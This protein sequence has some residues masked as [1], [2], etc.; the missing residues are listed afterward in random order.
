VSRPAW[1]PGDEWD[2]TDNLAVHSDGTLYRYA[3][4]DDE[5]AERHRVRIGSIDRDPV[6]PDELAGELAELVA[7]WEDGLRRQDLERELGEEWRATWM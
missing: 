4:D 1:R 6:V 5:W 2:W 3:V 7:R